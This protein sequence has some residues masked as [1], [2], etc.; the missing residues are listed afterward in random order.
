VNVCGRFVAEVLAYAHS[1]AAEVQRLAAEADARRLAGQRLSLRSQSKRSAEMVEILMGDVEEE[2]NPFSGAVMLRRKDV[3]RPE[4]MWE[5]AT[6]ES[7]EQERVPSAY[8]VPASLAEVVNRLSAHGIRL[9]RVATE[10][11]LPLEQF[12]METSAVADREFEQH[13]E[14]TT[15]GRYAA[16]DATVPAGAWRVD[17]TQPLARLAFYLLEPRSNDSLLTWNFLDEVLRNA[18]GRYPILRT[19]D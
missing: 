1:N 6:F 11:R 5:Y 2:I 8:Y 3:R 16:V 14:R 18:G 15:T 4:R 12:T 13:R 17:M 10:Q 9:E 7:T 19:R